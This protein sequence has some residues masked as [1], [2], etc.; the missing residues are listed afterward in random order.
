[1]LTVAI[2]FRGIAVGSKINQQNLCNFLSE[3]QVVLK[4]ILDE[5]IFSFKD[6]QAAFDHLYAARHTGKVVI[7]M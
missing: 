4:P 5:A 3:K 7:K 2:L 6:S 1:M